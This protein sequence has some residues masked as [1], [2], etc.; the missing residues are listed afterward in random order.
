MAYLVSEQTHEIGIRMALGAPREKVLG[1]VFRHGMLT[2]AT[3]LAAGLAA[4]WALARLMA[5]LVWGVTATDPATFVGVPLA[6]VAAAA[7]AIYVPARRA[8]NIH[9]I[10]ALRYE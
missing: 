8:M 6:L 7:L 9:P 2:T 4:A 5:S 3:G 1:M 10:A